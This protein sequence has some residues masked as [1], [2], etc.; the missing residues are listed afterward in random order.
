MSR[1]FLLFSLLA[2]LTPLARAQQLTA[3][4]EKAL[5]ARLSAQ[6]V[7]FPALTAEFTEERTTRLLSKPLVGSG[8]IAFQAPNKFRRELR[9]QSPSLTVCNGIELWIHYPKFQ[10]AEHYTLGRRQFFDDSLAALTAGLN[11]QQVEKFFRLEPSHDGAGYKVV[12][13]PKSSSLRQILTSL[14]VWLNADAI[15]EKT[16]AI[17]PK[18]D[19]MVTTY[20]NVRPAKQSSAKFDFTPP[21][22]THVSTPLDKE[23]R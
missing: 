14:T 22:D 9:G 23:A 18:G 15:I 10:E 8:T 4:E 7:E 19:R 5:L 3:A 13:K 1:F 2:T 16:D 11:F 21:A 6:R 17:L 12:L 20:R